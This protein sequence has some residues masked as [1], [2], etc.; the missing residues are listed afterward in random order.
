MSGIPPRRFGLVNQNMIIPALVNDVK[1]FLYSQII[2]S[3]EYE[4][5]YIRTHFCPGDPEVFF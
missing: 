2:I 1:R 4:S 5:S 3:R